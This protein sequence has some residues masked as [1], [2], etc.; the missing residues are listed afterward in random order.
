ML[1]EYSNFDDLRKF[2]RVAFEKYETMKNGWLGKEIS[3]AIKTWRKTKR[4]SY[5]NK[6]FSVEHQK[7]LLSIFPRFKANGNVDKNKFFFNLITNIE[8]K[9]GRMTITFVRGDNL[10]RIGL[11]HFMKRFKE[12]FDS[13][14]L[15]STA[16]TDVVTEIVPYIRNGKKYELLICDDSIIVA[17]RPEKDI[18]IFI[19]FLH[20]DM[21]NS[22]N[23]Q[24]L[25]EMAGKKI[26][27]DDVYE[28]K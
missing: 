13:Q 14:C 8:T 12:R 16:F 17:K 23:Y 5:F 24:A 6:V 3:K 9:H 27:E 4:Y 19:T 26:D 18:H 11:P 28:W 10:I 20:R 25:F 22:K 1:T 15:S 2:K 21:C 7:C